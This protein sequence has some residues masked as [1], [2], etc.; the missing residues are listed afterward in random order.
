[1][2]LSKS[3]TEE[4]GEMLTDSFGEAF[5]QVGKNG[6]GIDFSAALGGLGQALTA[7]AASPLFAPVASAVVGAI[8]DEVADYFSDDWD[9][10]AARQAAQGT[11]T[12]LGSI[13]AK[14][15][16]IAKAVDISADA[17]SQLVGINRAMLR[18]LESVQMGIEGASSRVARGYT[19]AQGGI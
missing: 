18:A 16:S 7:A 17:T 1:G 10:T 3:F 2:G 14:S 4:I 19:G 5:D 12:V 15:E 13:N 8:A 9:P 6:G 11:G